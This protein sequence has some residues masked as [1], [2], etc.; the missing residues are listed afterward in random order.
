PSDSTTDQPRARI[1]STGGSDPPTASSNEAGLSAG[2]DSMR[3]NSR[4]FVP[5]VIPSYWIGRRKL[6][7][8]MTVVHFDPGGRGA[9]L[10]QTTGGRVGCQSIPRVGSTQPGRP[11]SSA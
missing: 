7:Q 3:L 9:H 1:R 10:S 8:V 2:T 5:Y 11:M 4:S 6:S